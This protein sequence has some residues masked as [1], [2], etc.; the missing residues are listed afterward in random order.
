MVIYV[1]KMVHVLD[2][3]CRIQMD[4]FGVIQLGHSVYWIVCH[5]IDVL[6]CV[7]AEFCDCG[8]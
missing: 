1:V 3:L 8:Y 7:D 6:P 4:F 2:E 5:C